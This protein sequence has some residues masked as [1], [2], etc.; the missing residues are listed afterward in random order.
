ME[1]DFLTL[2]TTLASDALKENL[3]RWE[4]SAYRVA[5]DNRVSMRNCPALTLFN[6]PRLN[7]CKLFASAIAF[8]ELVIKHT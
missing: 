2:H 7:K 8:A 4:P 1:D 5:F 6:A 3:Q